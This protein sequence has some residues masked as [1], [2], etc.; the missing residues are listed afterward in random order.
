MI[1]KLHGKKTWHIPNEHIPIFVLA[2]ANKEI[3]MRSFEI[4]Y[5]C[6][7]YEAFIFFGSSHCI[8]Y[9][10]LSGFVVL[11][12]WIE[13]FVDCLSVSFRKSHL[14]R[15]VF[16]IGVTSAVWGGRK[17]LSCPVIVCKGQ[18]KNVMF[19]SN[20]ITTR[21]INPYGCYYT[22]A[23]FF[24]AAFDAFFFYQAPRITVITKWVLCGIKK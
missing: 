20:I 24:L 3:G 7:R 15:N 2:F 13:L 11:K 12:R 16:H 4:R 10:S 1:T 5:M 6:Y 18:S 19:L 8:R 23:G 14:S 21:S 17:L 9:L 22:V